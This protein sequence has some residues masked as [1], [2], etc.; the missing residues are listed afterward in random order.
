MKK[1][2]WWLNILVGISL[3]LSYLSVWIPPNSIEIIPLFGLTFPVWV[4]S[5]LFFLAYWLF[6]KKRKKALLPFFI[7][8]LGW[9]IHGSFFQINFSNSSSES[10]L[11]V[12]TFNTR[13]LDYYDWIDGVKTRNE[14]FDVI[15]KESPDVMCFQEFFYAKQKGE[16][17]TRDSILQFMNAPYYQE[18]YTHEMRG[19][20]FFGIITISK[21]PILSKGEIPFET[22]DNNF[23]IYTDIVKNSDTTRVYNVHLASIRFQKEDYEYLENNKDKQDNLKNGKRIAQRLIRAYKIREKQ[24]ERVL[25]SVHESPYPV[26]LC[27]DFNDIPVSWNYH[28]YK[29]ELVDSFMEAGLGISSTYIGKFPSFRIDY[30]FHSDEYICTKY[31][32]I[33][34]HLSDHKPVVVSLKKVDSTSK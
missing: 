12:M 21:Y 2:L 30:V 24:T 13:L 18:K 31:D 33:Q 10:D 11:K 19:K 26:V 20:R 14:I 4:I 17:E 16:Y 25:D 28:Q 6:I 5:N 29:N 32:V 3:I 9:N 1:I 34:E 22:D 23:C 7:L 15:Q 8:L 27:G